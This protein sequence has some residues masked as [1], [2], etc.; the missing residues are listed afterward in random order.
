MRFNNVAK[1]SLASLVAG[2]VTVVG[3]LFLFIYIFYPTAFTKQQCKLVERNFDKL[4]VGMTREEVFPLIG[5]ER[6]ATMTYAPGRFLREKAGASL[7]EQKNPWQVMALCSHPEK[8]YTWYFIAFDTK[9]NKV[10]KIFSGPP[11]ANG[12]D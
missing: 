3:G 11:D 2:I 4:K 12:F 1:V 10:V 9:T 8:D 5:G 7:R 6:R